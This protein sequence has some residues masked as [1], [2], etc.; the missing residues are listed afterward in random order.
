MTKVLFLGDVHI[1]FS[2]LKD[3]DIL[4]TKMKAI[5]SEGDV[6]IVVIAGDVLHK[7]EIVNV[8]LM[9]RAYDL[10]RCMRNF[11][12]VYVLVGNHD[13]IN[14]Q[15]FLTTNHWMNGMKEWKNVYVVDKP[16]HLKMKECDFAFVP[17]VPP[18]RLVEAL[19]EL[20][21]EWKSVDCIFAHQEIRGC[22]MGYIDSLDGDVWER[23][24][25]MLISGHIHERQRLK[26][27]VLYPGSVLNHAFGSDNQGV[28]IFTFSRGEDVKEDCVDLGLE[29]K[30]IVYDSVENFSNIPQEKIHVRNKLHLSGKIEEV[31]A[32]KSSKEYAD[33]KSKGIKV[34]FKLMTDEQE[35]VKSVQIGEKV[36]PFSSILEDFIKEKND[37]ELENDFLHIS[38][39]SFLE[40]KNV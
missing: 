27:N 37:P 1:Q 7:H 16:L 38:R 8:Q 11:V 22:K 29:K 9:N 26:E 3:V 32:F 31:K 4:E 28:S 2:N 18:G 33:L 39:K 40:D 30:M 24:W 6:D 35:N 23:D 34:V 5:L 19:E 13:Y 17:Y 15:Q 25:P 20:K 21:E 10:I 12:P 36:V 14:N